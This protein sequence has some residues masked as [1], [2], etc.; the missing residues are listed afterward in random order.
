MA[1]LAVAFVLLSAI[2]YLWQRYSVQDLVRSWMVRTLEAHYPVTV[3]IASLE[4]DLKTRRLIL[5]GLQINSARFPT[6]PAPITADEIEIHFIYRIW[7]RLFRVSDVFI[8]GPNIRVQEDPN[9]LLNITNMFR[10]RTDGRAGQGFSLS[11]LGGIMLDNGMLF[12]I[13]RSIPFQAEGRDLQARFFGRGDGR[14]YTLELAATRLGLNR[15]EASLRD[16]KME[17]DF[18]VGN[19]EIAFRKLRLESDL[20]GLDVEQAS[21]NYHTLEYSLR[22]KGRIELER[23]GYGPLRRIN[24]RGTVGLD[25]N[26]RGSG[27]DFNFS[28]MVTA[29]R[30]QVRKYLFAGISAPAQ[31]TPAWF[32][33]EDLRGRIFD[34]A[35][36]SRLEL[37]LKAG[38]LSRLA[39]H[40]EDA[41]IEAALAVLAIPATNVTGRIRSE[42]QLHWPD[43]RV[44]RSEAAITA[45]YTGRLVATQAV[46]QSFSGDLLEP[47][48]YHGAAAVFQT[49]T[50]LKIE[51][52]SAST[53]QSQVQSSGKVT[54]DGHYDL[55]LQ[56]QTEDG[57]ELLHAAGLFDTEAK[58]QMLR[59]HAAASAPADF[60]GTISGIKTSFRLAG[61][62]KAAEM[63]IEE[64]K[65]RDLGGRVEWT[66]RFF[67]LQEASARLGDSALSG[68]LRYPLAP[69]EPIEAA[70]A[71]RKAPV[72]DLLALGNWRYPARGILTAQV[73]A[74]G[75]SFDS[76]E[77]SAQ[78]RLDQPEIYGESF[79][80]VT[81]AV[82][83]HGKEYATENLRAEKERGW[84]TG[85]VSGR[86][87]STRLD[88][89]LT[90]RA[91]P[92]SAIESARQIRYALG[93][94]LQF[95]LK[96]SGTLDN[97]NH[98]LHA[99]VSDFSLARH[100]L[101]RLTLD[102]RAAGQQV[103][104]QASTGL[105][106]SRVDGRG[107]IQL[108]GDY[109]FEAALDLHNAP[110]DAYVA[111]F[112]PERPAT[113][114]GLATGSIDARGTWRH[115]RDAVVEA[116]FGALQLAVD[117]YQLRNEGEVRLR[118]L[119]GTVDVEPVSMIGPG[120]RL[121]LS[122]QISTA[123]R[124]LNLSVAGSADLLILT[125]F[126]PD[127]KSSGKVEINVHAGGTVRQPQIRGSASLKEVDLARPDW[128]TPLFDVSGLL[129]FTA[130]QVAVESVT[131]RTHYGT[132]EIEGGMFLEGLTPSRG[133]LNIT[134]D[135]LRIEYPQNVRCTV[136]VDVDYLKN[137]GSQLLTGV[138]YIRDAAYVQDITLAELALQVSN[139]R[140]VRPPRDYRQQ[141]VGLNLDVEAYKTLRIKNNLADI[142]GSGVFTL[143]GTLSDPAI[144]GRVNVD[145]GKLI[146][147]DSSYDVVHGVVTFSNPHRIIPVMDF[148]AETSV[149]DYTV[150][151]ALHGPLD[152]LTTSFRSDPPLTT[153][154]IVTMLAVG[155]PVQEIASRSGTQEERSQTLAFHGASTFLSR[156]LTE[157]LT[158]R[159]TRL[160]GFDRFT[161]DPFIFTGTT[162]AARVTL[163]KQLSR[164]L[165]LIF[166]TDLSSTQNEV[167]TIQYTLREGLTLVASRNETGSFALD[168]KLRKRF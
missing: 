3:Q 8:R 5:H 15:D 24:M 125:G 56:V 65:L 18:Q 167:V 166:A 14:G 58:R 29:N 147:Q 20:A 153:S 6:Q 68:S 22:G 97:L 78:I 113:L 41:R 83:F 152:R 121:N 104:V 146:L 134:A 141:D 109:P 35:F 91:I 118:Y 132:L 111:L 93:G 27:R 40:I 142:I 102:A 85:R 45:D 98:T 79:R 160:F 69:G 11:G 163:G 38:S 156:S 90:G 48:P 31:F 43:I 71:I 26:L 150:T 12:Y 62:F 159:S 123:G 112:Q 149:R 50:T 133:R 120:T 126:I 140:L 49:G 101:Q 128:P 1:A 57:N 9:G 51:R 72:S 23:V 47:I 70:A 119:R 87:D 145:Q 32:R 100:P 21:V 2:A 124:A 39:G 61:A 158:S 77:G 52:A 108:R 86:M 161:V 165:S 135:G 42:F 74:R 136:D 155:R 80:R 144:L 75:E 106:N 122:G 55:K 36:R 64:V 162:P 44:E 95:T 139:Y 34:G 105:R 157:K 60:D 115:P 89:D 103:D 129:R 137:A 168:V 92:L 94:V 13:N 88:L 84:I 66:P 130:D 154:E 10:P 33:S 76:M 138:I 53:P 114:R 81:A 107:R 116:R 148:E 131:A 25:G 17:A 59:R 37:G 151:I 30:L 110:V 46:A 16:F 143:G 7:N 127:L 82:K 28:G 54:L 19:E 99:E 67:L 4:L 96:G 164:N 63:R 73:H 117:R